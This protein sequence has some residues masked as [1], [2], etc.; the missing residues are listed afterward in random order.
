MANKRAKGLR[1]G[2]SFFSTLHTCMVW[3]VWAFRVSIS[4]FHQYYYYYFDGLFDKLKILH[5]E[6]QM[7]KMQFNKMFRLNDEMFLLKQTN[8]MNQNRVWPFLFPKWVVTATASILV[9]WDSVMVH[10]MDCLNC[11]VKWWCHAS[12]EVSR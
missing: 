7:V 5:S 1:F 4:S 8:K 2:Y 9:T 12:V 10:C 11:A 3:I 6:K